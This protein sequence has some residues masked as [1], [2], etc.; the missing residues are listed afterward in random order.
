MKTLKIVIVSA[1]VSAVIT[2]LSISYYDRHF[3]AKIAV[4]DMTGYVASLKNA[5]LAGKLPKAELDARLKRLSERINSNYSSNTVVLLK[6]VVVS[7]K[8]QDLTPEILR[9]HQK[10]DR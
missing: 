6:E 5:Y 7:G 4:M 1:L 2:A 3:A 8:V 10:A 9:E